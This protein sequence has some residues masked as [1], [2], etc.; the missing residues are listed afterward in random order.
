M[1][2][3]MGQLASCQSSQPFKTDQD[4]KNWLLRLNAY[5]TWLDTAENRM[6]EGIATG[7]VSPKSL[8]A[9]V[10]P[11]LLAMTNKNIEEHLFYSPIKNFPESFSEEQKKCSRVIM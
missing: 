5:I 4:Y 8:I 6:K 7:N 1:Q 10:T 11:Q 2:L 9:K 3:S